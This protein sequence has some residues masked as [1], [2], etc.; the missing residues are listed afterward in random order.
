MKPEQF[1]FQ[2]E[3]LSDT[4]AYRLLAG[5]FFIYIFKLSVKFSLPPYFW[6]EL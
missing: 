6:A 1:I 4:F 5:L 2:S 3:I